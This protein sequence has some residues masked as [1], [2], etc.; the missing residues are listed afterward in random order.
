M[1]VY[2]L[3]PHMPAVKLAQYLYASAPI[4][5]IIDWVI[6]KRKFT[7]LMDFATSIGLIGVIIILERKKQNEFRYEIN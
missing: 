3:I 6:C 7:L 2:C 5:C 4:S 1:F